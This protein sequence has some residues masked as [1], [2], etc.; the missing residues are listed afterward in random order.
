MLLFYV[1][2]LSK[3]KKQKQKQ[4][5]KQAKIR[6]KDAIYKNL[7]TW[8]RNSNKSQNIFL[9]HTQKK[10]TQKENLLNPLTYFQITIMTKYY[11]ENSSNQPSNNS[12]N[13]QYI[14][15]Y[16]MTYILFF[17]KS[18]GFYFEKQKSHDLFD[19]D[20]TCLKKKKDH[21]I[22]YENIVQD[23]RQY[24]HIQWTKTV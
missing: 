5:Q 2:L 6:S 8:L 24:V 12:N 4:K 10:I 9:L 1:S 13:H 7:E 19:R 15:F 11:L 22:Y 23:N 20:E 17:Q 3:K 18:Y 21:T 16:H 14:F